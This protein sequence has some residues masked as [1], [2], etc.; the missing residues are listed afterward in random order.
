MRISKLLLAVCAVACCMS[1]TAVRAVDNPAQAA[2][3]AALMK[4]MNEWDVQAPKLTPPPAVVTHPNA[5]QKQPR[6]PT[7]APTITSPPA[8]HAVTVQQ[9]KKPAN[10]S[11]PGRELGLKPIEAPPLPIS[12]AKKAQLQALLARYKAD[13]I[14]PEQYHTERAEI[15]VEP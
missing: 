9:P 4:M 3:R 11:Y 13:Q 2:C 5:P 1:V 7:H 10:I 14:T 8:A 6:Q 12:A 15:L